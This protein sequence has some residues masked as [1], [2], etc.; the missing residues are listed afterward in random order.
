MN[1]SDDLGHI[2]ECPS[3][4]QRFTENVLPFD[5]A[6]RREGAREF[7]ATAERLERERDGTADIVARQLSDTPIEEWPRLAESQALR[8]NAALEQL[9]EEVRKRIDRD[10]IAALAIANVATSIAESLPPHSYPPVVLSQIRATAWRDRANAL[11]YLARYE[12]ALESIDRS[13]SILERFATVAHDRAITRLVKAMILAQTER[14]DEAE[15]MIAE[16]RAV[17]LDSGDS[18]RYLSAGLVQANTLYRASRYAD[19]REIYK[20]LLRDASSD[21]ESQARLHNNLG[22]CATHLGDYV[23]A[24]IHFSEAVARFVDLGYSAEIPRTERGA[25]LVLLARGQTSAGIAHLREARSAFTAF[26]MAEEAGLCGLNIAE[27]LIDRG[28]NTEAITLIETV[29]AEFAAAGLDERAISAVANLRDAMHADDAT[30]ETVRTV[31]VYVES[32]R[33]ARP[34]SLTV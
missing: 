11:R 1:H 26:A 29:A 5:A 27:V 20:D 22:Y 4:R 30:A 2:A 31:H 24:K 3:C 25:G 17:F 9:S 12:E 10:N 19:A 7:A 33:A 8:N 21:L 28:Q 34:P 32:L 13:E 18:K 14:F 16:C 23:A 15:A 6:R